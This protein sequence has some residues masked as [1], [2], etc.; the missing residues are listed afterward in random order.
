MRKIHVAD[1]IVSSRYRIIR[2]VDEGGMQEVYLAYDNNINREVALKTPKN[3][4]ASKRFQRSALASSKINHVNIAR[5]LDYFVFQEREYLIE[6]FVDGA[7]LGHIF[8]ENFSYLDPLMVA[9]IGNHLA[10]GIKS[11][12]RVNVIHRDL[13]PS[14]IMVKGGISFKDI[15]ITDFGVARLVDE[16]FKQINS[17]DENSILASKTL[18]GAVPYMAP[19]IL[20][21]NAEPSLSSDIWSVGA[22]LYFLL[23]GK[24]PYSMNL[25][26]VIIAYAQNKPLPIIPHL[27][28]LKHARELSVQLYGIILSCMNYKPELRPTAEE[29]VDQFSKLCYMV[30]DRNVGVLYYFKGRGEQGF[31][32]ARDQSTNKSI[33][34]HMDEVFGDKP[35][36]DDKVCF[37]SYE[38]IP[39][40]RAFPI[41]KCK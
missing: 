24:T 37:S 36:I 3:L 13:K 1:D 20:I 9:H 14:N 18:V 11:S 7:T 2:Y 19:E 21:G 8:S 35:I 29:L 38:G 4:S 10:R 31:G 27:D 23:A 22:I 25:S 15:K 17:N 30:K 39:R 16:E 28:S 41:I 32:F 26:Q 34:I 40:A 33:M 6:E 5:T 12:H